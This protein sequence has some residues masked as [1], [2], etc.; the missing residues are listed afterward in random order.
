MWLNLAASNGQ[1][2]AAE[3]RNLLESRMTPT[4]VAEAQTRARNLTVKSI[5]KQ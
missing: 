4:Q 2:K 5:P 1:E 3:K